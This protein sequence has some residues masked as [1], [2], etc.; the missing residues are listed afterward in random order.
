M[1]KSFKAEPD[2]D[3]VRHLNKVLHKAHL[4][5]S[6]LWLP[7]LNHLKAWL[8]RFDLKIYR[9]VSFVAFN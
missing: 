2:K 1:Q 5:K 9:Y 6:L 8:C 3:K 7:W 4:L